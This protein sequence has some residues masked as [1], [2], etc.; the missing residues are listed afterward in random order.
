MKNSDEI[1]GWFDYKKTYTYLVS[2]VV[3]NGI[4]VECGAWLGKSSS[5][6]C[7]RAEDRI[8]VFIVDTWEGS[9]D[10]N[11]PTNTLAKQCDAYDIFTKNMGDRKY[12]AI[13]RLSEDAAGH[14][15]NDSCD[16]VFIDMT[17]TYEAVKQDILTWLPKVKKNGYIAGHDYQNDW[18]GVVTAVN[19]IFGS[20]NLILMDTCWIYRKK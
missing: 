1:D 15:A 16:V 11:D 4:F 20:E 19:E 7:D 17:H 14:F 6:L 18:P 2:K 3:D 10:N 13:K 5:Y 12:I 9:L 8:Q